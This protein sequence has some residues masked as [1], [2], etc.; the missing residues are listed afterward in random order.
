MPSSDEL[1]EALDAILDGALPR[2][3]ET[4]TLDFKQPKHSKRETL[5]MLV[6]A[7]LCFANAEGG[8]V[9]LGVSDRGS[10]PSA[11]VGTDVTRDEAQRQIY[12]S[13]RPPLLVD[14]RSTSI[15]GS[16]GMVVLL[17]IR[18]P[19]SLEIHSDTAGRAPRRVGTDCLP[20]DPVQQRM[21]QEERR[22]TDWSAGST[23][24]GT[25]SVDRDAID[26]ARR[27]LSRFADSRRDL[28]KASKRDL[29]RGLGVLSGSRLSR[30]GGLLFRSEAEPP[31]QILYQY[32]TTAGGEPVAVERLGAP[33]V[34]AFEE[35]IRLIN[36]RTQMTP[37]TLPDGQQL[38]VEDFPELAIREAVANALIHRDYHFLDQPVVIDHSPEIFGI[39]SPGPLVSGV[40][41]RNILT[42]PS[43]PRNPALARAA[44]GLG[45][46]EEVGR[47]VDR[48]YREMLRFGRE[49]PTIESTLD[50]VRVSL[51]GGAPN[52][53][54]A[55]F[56]AELPAEERDDVD[57]LL[58]LFFLCQNKT[59]TASG[60]A[61]ILQKSGDEGE[62]VL[63]RL[64]GPRVAMLEPTRESARRSRPTYRL[65]GAILQELGSAICYHR[66][67]TDEIDRK[68][69]EH[70]REYGR[71]TNKTV[72][73][74]LDVKVDRGAAILRDLVRRDIL[75]KTSTAQ[76]GPSVE[77]GRGAKF[78][79][80]G[81][82]RRESE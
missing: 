58:I 60:I 25:A 65:R 13:T 47:G 57:T 3:L 24:F 66:R 74:L 18:V 56:V 43:K 77:Y 40:T 17:E 4:Q 64:T 8:S 81:A 41:P 22:G 34:I 63:R 73:N 21:L 62:A 28:A 37:L 32:R 7:A 53:Q 11:F 31:V 72:R 71:I 35:C 19:Q 5:R 68:V 14:A 2:D 55:R 23:D 75:V 46:A 9:I 15:R 70:V 26:A 12:D 80:R 69:I 49:I 38:Q 76:R 29:L 1:K 45:L 78:P 36:A 50:G 59:V 51:V 27:R 16:K 67:T 6:N 33:L 52:T 48:M 82:R 54:I 10:G 42:H 39:T 79:K 44:R 20:L 61:P 30:A